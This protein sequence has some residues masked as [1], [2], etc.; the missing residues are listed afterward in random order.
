MPEFICFKSFLNVLLYEFIERLFVLKLLELKLKLLNEFFLEILDV[1]NIIL[2]LPILEFIEFVPKLLV[3][4]VLVKVP[5]ILF[6]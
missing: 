4:V 5:Y 2:L 3:N 6:K 1:P